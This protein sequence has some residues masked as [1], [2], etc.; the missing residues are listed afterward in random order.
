M[1]KRRYFTIILIPHSSERT[2]SI[3][4]PLY[5]IWTT[6]ATILLAI[7]YSLFL[8]HSYIGIIDKKDDLTAQVHTLQE[9][10]NQKESEIKAYELEMQQISGYLNN[11]KDLELQVRQKVGLELPTPSRSNIDRVRL[12][13]ASDS[14]NNEDIIEELQKTTEE[15][16]RLLE[17]IAAR[18]KYLRNVPNIYPVRGRI[19]SR[20]GN[21]INPITMSREFHP[22]LDIEADYG[23][24]VR[25]ASDGVVDFAGVKSGYGR[26]VII[27]NSYGFTTLYGH[28]SKLLV[29][30]GQKIKKGDPIAKVGSSGLSTGP[31]VHFE[32]YKGGVRVD[33]LKYLMGGE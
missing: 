26:T 7:V 5:L 6:L 30:V 32:V 17:E 24:T 22:G 18:E 16:Q 12:L 13:K 29:K 19:T 11:L 14:Q 15:Y 31:H 1:G 10:K 8:T 25:A 2:L 20:Y 33:P 28:N 4:I 27:K 9:E 3:K 23:T 21:R